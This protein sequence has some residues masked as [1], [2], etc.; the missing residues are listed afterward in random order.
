MLS[1]LI[2]LAKLSKVHGSSEMC[3]LLAYFA[4]SLASFSANDS[5]ESLVISSAVT[6]TKSEVPINLPPNPAATTLG[7][8]LLVP[9]AMAFNLVIST[10][11]SCSTVVIVKC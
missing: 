9:A 6:L 5:I 8:F 4:F 11:S 2:F 3:F 7:T 1:Q 10:V